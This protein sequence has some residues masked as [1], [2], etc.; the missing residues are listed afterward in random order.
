MDL[1]SWRGSVQGESMEPVKDV[2]LFELA[3]RLKLE[4]AAFQEY[5]KHG[6]LDGAFL[7]LRTMEHTINGLMERLN[8]LKYRHEAQKG[9]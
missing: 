9:S 3:R 1:W 5:L 7:R 6:L 2:M 4:E 8:D